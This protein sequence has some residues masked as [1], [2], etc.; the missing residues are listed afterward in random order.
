MLLGSRS[1]VIYCLLYM[2]V[3]L[4]SEDQ[5]CVHEHHCHERG[6][7]NPSLTSY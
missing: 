5:T 3:P 1:L 7:Q 2:S 4:G 6:S